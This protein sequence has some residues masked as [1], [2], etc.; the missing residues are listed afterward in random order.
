[1][2]AA[3]II[4]ENWGDWF[5]MVVGFFFGT[6]ATPHRDPMRLLLIRPITP[7]P[8]PDPD[9]GYGFGYGYGYGYPS[10]SYY[11]SYYSG[12]NYENDDESAL[13]NVLAEYTVSWNRHDTAAVIRLFTENCDYVNIAGI[14]WKGV[15]EIV[16]QHAELFQNRL[17]TALRTLPVRNS[18]STPDVALVYATWDVTGSTRPAERPFQF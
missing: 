9:T 12:T 18:A 13:R 8:D 2:L 3:T 5:S 11:G 10:G 16:Q 17:K 15:Q 4:K 7:Y 6:G 1:M 14:H